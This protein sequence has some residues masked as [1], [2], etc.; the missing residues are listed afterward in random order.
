MSAPTSAT[1]MSAAPLPHASG[2][3][4][5]DTGMDQMTGMVERLAQKLKGQPNNA[6][7][8]AMLA[9]SYGVLGRHAESLK[10]YEKALTLRKGDVVLQTDYA[11]ELVQASAAAKP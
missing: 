4:P 10:A 2:A 11:R 9:R 7:G 1:A 3:A 6:E 5:H 8:W